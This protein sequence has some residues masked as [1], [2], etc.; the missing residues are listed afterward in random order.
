MV[1]PVMSMLLAATCLSL[2]AFLP[3]AAFAV[4][5]DWVPDLEAGKAAYEANCARCH[6]PT[7]EGDGPDAKKM[8]PQ[9]RKLSDGVF[10]FRTTASG[11]PPTDEDLMAIL[12]T[13]LPGSRM[14]DFQR[15]PEETRANL[16]AYVK[17]LSP[18]FGEQKPEPI[19]LGVDPGPK[20]AD[21]LKGKQVYKELG[22]A[23]CHGEQGRA[24]GSSAPTLADNWGNPIRAADLT[25]GWA[26]RGGSA[27]RDIVARFLSGIDGTPMP[28]YV[29][30]ISSKEDAWHLAY[31][32][33]S[34][35]E[36][37]HWNRA[38]E[39]VKLTGELPTSR[40]DPR[41]ERAPRTDLRLSSLFY[42]AGVILPAMVDSILVQAVYN[43]KEIVFKFIW[44][45]PSESRGT[46]SEDSPNPLPD[47]LGLVIN[48]DRRSKFKVGSLRSWPAS[49][50]APALDL[51]YWSANKSEATL[52]TNTRG[53]GFTEADAVVTGMEFIPLEAKAS[54][55]DGQWTLLVRQP[56]KLFHRE[57]AIPERSTLI[58]IAVWEG[59]N[60]EQG[61]R[62]ANSY[63][64]DL[65]LKRAD[66]KIILD[67]RGSR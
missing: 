4:S 44:N 32:V 36:T 51:C 38:I 45:D 2:V 47:A 39:A 37:P 58:G 8:F 25:H 57:G 12:A 21:V 10:K 62:R 52:F 34:L 5:S 55:T 23:A 24:N 17:T 22:C 67:P 16:V 14:P 18:V 29:D 13:G 54:Y 11:T 19:D 64:V 28:S 6:G 63:W 42:Q 40:E 15:L 46:P 27:P 48:P 31:Y 66:S 7:G 56:M 43:E 59:G 3:R 26:Y 50:D 65:V 41:W 61:R 49:P 20:K 60:N 33:H 1:S 53:F 30:A 35:Q 9:P